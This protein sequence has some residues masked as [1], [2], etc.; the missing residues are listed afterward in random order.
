MGG[1]ARESEGDGEDGDVGPVWKGNRFGVI[2][3]PVV[4]PAWV[5]LVGVGSVLAWL[6]T[7]HGEC[8]GCLEPVVEGAR[9]TGGDGEKDGVSP[10]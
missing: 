1:G 5:R 2:S 7:G 9:E 10:V 8:C 4:R 3:S 6:C